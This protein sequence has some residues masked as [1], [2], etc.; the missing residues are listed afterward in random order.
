MKIERIIRLLAGT[1]VLTGLALAHWVHPAW[2]WL[3]VF[4][5]VNLVQSSLTGFCPPELLLK[6]LGVG[7]VEEGQS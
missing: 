1:V 6:K 4:A 3:S 7:R 5:G 2:V